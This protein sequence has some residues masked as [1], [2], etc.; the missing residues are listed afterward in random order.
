MRRLA[1][2]AFLATVA[3]TAAS[4]ARAEVRDMNGDRRPDIVISNKKGVHVFL[5]T[6]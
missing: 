3:L 2:S 4:L 1:S 5:Q 6:R